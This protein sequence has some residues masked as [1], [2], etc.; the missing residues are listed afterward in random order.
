MRI[1]P[2][3]ILSRAFFE[4]RQAAGLTVEEINPRHPPTPRLVQ[5][6]AIVTWEVLPRLIACLSIRC[7]DTA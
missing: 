6:G 5:V 4:S 3:G 2:G 1:N 7:Y